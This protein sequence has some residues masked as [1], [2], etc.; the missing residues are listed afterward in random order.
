MLGCD[1]DALVERINTL[2]LMGMDIIRFSFTSKE[3]AG[4]LKAVASRS[5]VPI[6]CD[7]HF[8]YRLAIT[9]LESGA[10]KVRINP[11]NIG[12][13]WKTREVVK[14]AKDLG[15]CIRIGLN[16]GSLPSRCKGMMAHEAMARAALDYINIVESEG[17]QNTVVS[18]KSSD[19]DETV[20]AALLF[21]SLSPYPQHLGV[22]EAGDPVTSAVRSA[23]ALGRI[24]SSGAGDTLRISMTGSMEDEVIAASELLRCLGLRKKGVRLIS[25][26]RCGRHTFDTIAFTQRIR[27]RLMALDKPVTVA[28]MG[29]PVNGPGEAKAA[30]YAITGTG[31]KVSVYSHG[32]MVLLVE[33]K[34]AERAL[35]EVIDE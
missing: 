11:G 10:D 4:P 28:V 26:P 3:E 1:I 5:P 23:W 16:T 7:I 18:L 12:A 2:S 30:D 31:G 24:L 35:F 29:C 6:V 21:A 13:E 9:A 25:C 33:E 34:D 20:K 14:C 22:T 32:K 19:G 15:R 8:D 17:F 27:P